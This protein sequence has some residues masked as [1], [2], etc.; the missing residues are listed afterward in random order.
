MEK[1]ISF[2]YELF[3]GAERFPV[4]MQYGY[5][6]RSLYLHSHEDFTELVI[7]LEG[8]AGHIVNNSCYSI[9]KGDVFVISSGTGH[10]FLDP[11]RLRIV[12][13][14]FRPDEAFRSLFDLRQ[15]PG[16]QL[17]FVLEPSIAGSDQFHSR[18]R[19]EGENFKAA[20]S[21]VDALMQEYTDKKS[22]WQDIVISGFIQLCVML[23]RLYPEQIT[24]RGGSP[25][26]LAK[27]AAYI[28]HNFTS[29]I[30]IEKLAE[31][32]GYSQRQTVRLF[33][34]IYGMTP[35]AYISQLRLKRAKEMLGSGSTSIA[36]VSWACGFDDQNYFSRFFRSHTGMTPTEY[37]NIGDYPHRKV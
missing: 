10:S 27:A 12:N 32:S 1:L 28:E 20:V 18:L 16:F 7:V 30:S 2:K 13:I 11:D 9:S 35:S 8:S 15:I 3:A 31:I 22:G 24:E 19:L 33:K 36:E 5:H 25:L 4:H 6:D 21:L 14:M 23:S 17:L 26:M 29:Q 34:Q 37:R